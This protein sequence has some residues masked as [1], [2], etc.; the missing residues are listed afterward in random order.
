MASHSRRPVRAA[1]LAAAL[2]GLAAFAGPAAAQ[3]GQGWTAS[4]ETVED[5]RYRLGLID[6]ELADIRARLGAVSGGEAQAPPSGGGAGADVGLRLDRLEAELRRLTGAVERIEFRQR[7]MAEDAAR[8][9]GDIEFRLTELEGG[10]VSALAPQPPLGEGGGGMD[11]AGDGAGAATRAG[12]GAGAA[13]EPA[14]GAEAADPE[15]S[16]PGAQQDGAG[17][18]AGGAPEPAASDG[19]RLAAAIREVQQGRFE[20]GEAGLREVIASEPGPGRKA[21]AQYW[22]GQSHFVRGDFREAARLFLAGYNTDP[23]GG[24]APRS[25]LQLGITLGR[26][27]QTREACL[28]LREVRNQFPEGH[29]EVVAAADAEADSL[30]CGGG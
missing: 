16:G 27:G 1:V 23:T 25:L 20:S 26:L 19:P 18:G 9:F 28:T 15:R 10:D 2:A 29:P 13:T 24:M 22:L 7:R 11:P 17:T 30:A 5:L 4:G 6:A 3:Q 12:D 21:R 8:R 14:A